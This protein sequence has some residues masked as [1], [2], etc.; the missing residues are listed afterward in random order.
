[1][2]GAAA[3]CVALRRAAPEGNLARSP[4]RCVAMSKLLLSCLLLLAALGLSHAA[5]AAECTEIT[6]PVFTISA[7]GHYCVGADLVT[8]QTAIAINASH[9]DLDCRGY[10]L[11]STNTSPTLNSYGV[12]LTGQSDVHVHHCHISGGFAAGIYAYQDNGFVNV[13]QNLDFHDNT[14]SGTYWF[15]VL[16]YGTDIVVRDNYI[17]RIGGRGSFAMGIRV[18]GSIQNTEPRSFVVRDNVIRDVTSPVNNSYG[19]YANNSNNG[20]Y[21]GNTITAPQ[22]GSSMGDWGIKIA[23]GA[24]NRITGN[25]V[26]G[27][28]THNA[29]GIEGVVSSD[30][31]Y[32]NHIRAYVPVLGCDDSLGNQ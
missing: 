14:I 30:A 23:G 28:S 27:S 11:R 1:V 4:H 29:I 31:C 6:T 18:G 15:G 19:I 13:N 2:A 25:Q 22:F 7:P 10:S 21:S 16:A 32:G 20:T 5:R 3:H 24:D 26:H 17:Y 9:V 8:A 12:Y